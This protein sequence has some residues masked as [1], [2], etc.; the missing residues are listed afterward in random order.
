MT[1][2]YKRQGIYVISFLP[3]I[4]MMCVIFFFSAQD[5]QNSGN[6]SKGMSVG[7]V[8]TVSR[9]SGKKISKQ[10]TLQ[11]AD[12][13][14]K[15]LRKVAH[16]TEYFILALLWVLPFSLH[17]YSE[18]KLACCILI[19]CVLTA[20]GDEL[21]QYFVSGRN[22]SVIDVG[23]DSVGVGIALLLHKVLHLFTGKRREKLI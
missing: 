11:F 14:E 7:I 23:I 16:M 6:M 22:A 5:A 9:L 4:L 13:I 2:N 1:K 12:W 19:I 18:K 21:H 15:P 10:N 8:K 3:A 17:G 20:A